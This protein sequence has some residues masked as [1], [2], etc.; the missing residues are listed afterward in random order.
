MW[1]EVLKIE[2]ELRSQPLT[3]RKA[4][5]EASVAAA[6]LPGSGIRLAIIG[7]GTSFF[8][9]QAMAALREA[10]GRGETDAFA[11]SEALLSRNYDAVLA[12]SRSGTTTEVLNAIERVPA[13][14]RRIAICADGDAP[15]VEAVDEVV[16]LPFADESSVVQTRFAT[17]ALALFRAHL[18]EAIEALSDEAERALEEPISVQLD[19][20]DRIVFLA[21]G[22]GVGLANEAALKLREAAGIWTESYPAMEYRH[23][24]ISATTPK[25]LVWALGT[26]DE[27]VLSDAEAAGA[28]IVE[29]QRDPMVELVLIHRAAVALAHSRGLDPDQPRNLARSV[30]LQATPRPE[31]NSYTTDRTGVIAATELSPD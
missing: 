2:H 20:F 16:L 4:A 22:W 5:Q 6:R 19:D 1:R 18:D 21:T 26:V 10:A 9:A 17:G 15:L 11:A 28:A 23:G 12:I 8:I 14:T 27:A 3:W 7:C 29:S 30:V 13:P 24:P 31:G 25:T